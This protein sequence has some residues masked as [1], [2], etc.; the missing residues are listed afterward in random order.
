MQR[1]RSIALLN[2]SV[3][4]GKSIERCAP[5]REYVFLLANTGFY[6]FC[7]LPAVLE[8]RNPATMYSTRKKIAGRNVFG[9]ST[10]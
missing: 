1:L 9:A 3:L 10:E 8:L 7:G 2:V 5:R 6:P 4:I